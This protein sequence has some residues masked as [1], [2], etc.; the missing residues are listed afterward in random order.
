MKK[1]IILDAELIIVEK[2]LKDLINNDFQVCCPK[3]HSTEY[4][5]YPTAQSG[6]N[7]TRP[8]EDLHWSCLKC[9]YIWN[10]YFVGK[11]YNFNKSAIEGR[12]SEIFKRE[13][14]KLKT[15]FRQIFFQTIR[16]LTRIFKAYIH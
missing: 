9:G 8:E 6:P 1:S 13:H 5:I 7:I 12:I 14:A 3:C 4:E 16:Y 15:R 10:S 2:E 11:R